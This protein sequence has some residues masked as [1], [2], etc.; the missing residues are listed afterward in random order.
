M[1]NAELARAVA[2]RIA[3]KRWISNTIFP[4]SSSFGIN[5]P[6]W[7]KQPVYPLNNYPNKSQAFK[8]ISNQINRELKRR[9]EAGIP[10]TTTIKTLLEKNEKYQ[11]N[12]RKL[13]PKNAKS[14]WEWA[15]KMFRDQINL[16]VLENRLINRFLS[17]NKVR[18]PKEKQAIEKIMEYY[19]SPYPVLRGKTGRGYQ[20]ANKGLPFLK[21]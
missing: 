8:N 10:L 2:T 19:Y 3:L 20:R 1:N 5:V 17:E 7:R 21:K 16:R 12:K 9:K 18:T 4:P 13:Y 11:T 15:K 14:S 6:N